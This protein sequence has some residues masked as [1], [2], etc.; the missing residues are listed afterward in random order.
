[1]SQSFVEASLIGNFVLP[2][3]EEI[4]PAADTMIDLVLGSYQGSPT[5]LSAHTIPLAGPTSGSFVFDSITNS[6]VFADLVNN[7][8]DGI[9][10]F[11]F[12]HVTSVGGVVPDGSVQAESTLFQSVSTN[13]IDLGGFVIEQIV[14]I[15]SELS[16]V[17]AGANQRV[18]V[19]TSIDVYGSNAAVP[20]PLSLLVWVGLASVA[21]LVKYRRRHGRPLPDSLE[22]LPC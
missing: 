15:Y 14:F 19:A 16:S 6:G 7:L 11:M 9:N 12:G 20:E 3:D 8:T 18:R 13:G 17:P 2:N 10:N 1:L 21:G 4:I 5:V 22:Q